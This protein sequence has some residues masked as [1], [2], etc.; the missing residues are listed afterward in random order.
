MFK[1]NGY[2]EYREDTDPAYLA[3]KAVD[4]PDGDSTEG[5]QYDRRFF[6]QVFG[7][8][9]SV[10]YDAYDNPE[11]SD[12]PDSIDNPEILT[13]LK[14]IIHRITDDI[15]EKLLETI[16]SL[17]SEIALREQ[18]H[19]NLLNTINGLLTRLAVVEGGLYNDVTTN[20]FEITFNNLNGLILVSGIWNEPM[21]R[22]ECT[23]QDDLINIAFEDMNNF[24]VIQGVYNT[25]LNRVEC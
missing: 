17:E 7:F 19:N 16:E 12:H 3:G 5:T 24:I 4:T 6:N 10:M 22:I 11:F 13:A 8:F 1:L 2:T 23:F 25:E 20:P 14:I 9:Q 18:Q 15:L 21:E